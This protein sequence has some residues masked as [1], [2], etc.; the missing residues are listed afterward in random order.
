M[1]TSKVVPLAAPIFCYALGVAAHWDWIDDNLDDCWRNCLGENGC[2]SQKCEYTTHGSAVQVHVDILI[3]TGICDASATDAFLENSIACQ[4]S[5][6][7]AEGWDLDFKLLAPLEMF[8][9]VF[10]NPIP[11]SILDNAYDCATASTV[12]TRKVEHSTTATRTRSEDTKLSATTSSMFTQTTTDGDGHTLQLVVP[13]IMGPNT[14]YTGKTVTKTIENSST[15]PTTSTTSSAETTISTTADPT[16]GQGASPSSSTPTAQ[17]TQKAPASGN[18]TPF[19]NMQASAGRFGV[20][21][22][23]AGLSCLVAAFMRL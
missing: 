18:G 7:D 14:M 16:Q 6:C 19:E 21:S 10:E 3:R 20:S 15:A 4:K 23:V 13:I 2:K 22:I 17:A 1:R 11:N 12:S 9:G 5:E 8:C